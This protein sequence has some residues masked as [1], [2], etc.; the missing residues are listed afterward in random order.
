MHSPF[1]GNK[2]IYKV[3]VYIAFN[4]GEELARHIAKTHNDALL[5]K[6][7]GIVPGSTWL[8]VGNK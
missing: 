4:V 8:N 5:H 1:P 7:L 2:T 3:P 6:V